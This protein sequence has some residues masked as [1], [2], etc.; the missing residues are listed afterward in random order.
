MWASF[1]VRSRQPVVYCLQNR[2]IVQA[3]VLLEATSIHRP[4]RS[5]LLSGLNEE[6]KYK[7]CYADE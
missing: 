2:S 4:R 5:R 1:F 3:F 6:L 7:I